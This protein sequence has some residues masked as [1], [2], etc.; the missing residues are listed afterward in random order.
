MP[1][2]SVSFTTSVQTNKKRRSTDVDFNIL[3]R[4]LE[5]YETN[6]NFEGE[7]HPNSGNK[8]RKT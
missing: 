4:K 6:S 1:G 8:V 2:E 7:K 3:K 5:F